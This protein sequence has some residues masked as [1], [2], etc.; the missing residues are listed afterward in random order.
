MFLSA[1][2]KKISIFLG[3][4]TSNLNFL[5][6]LYCI[7]I[8]IC[9]LFAK[10]EAQVDVL[11]SL[12]NRT[13][14]DLKT[15]VSTTIPVQDVLLDSMENEMNKARSYFYQSKHG[16]ALEIYDN[17][18]K[19]ALKT[20]N[21]ILEA[22]CY[23]G[24]GTN[25]F[26]VNNNDSLMFKYL[27]KAKDIFEKE[28]DPYFK[29][30]IYT[31]IASAYSEFEKLEKAN[32]YYQKAIDIA[33]SE[34]YTG[35]LSNALTN[36]GTIEIFEK[37]NYTKGIDALL[38]V[39]DIINNLENDNTRDSLGKVC[40]NLSY[41]YFKVGNKEKS[42]FY[43]NKGVA[44]AKKNG[45]LYVLYDL[46]DQQSIFYFED[47]KYKEAYLHIEEALFLK[48]SLNTIKDYE[49]AKQI[50]ADNFLKENKEQ[51]LLVE[52]EKEFQDTTLKRT[53][54]YNIL[55]AFFTLGLL[56][57]IYFIFKKNKQL[58]LAKEKAENLSKVKSDFYSEISH[59]LRTPL[60]AVIELSRLL[61]SENVNSEHK[62]Y[63][64]SLN[65]SGN[66]LL[67]L[68]NNVLEIN[69]V[70]HGD[71]KI[72]T[73]EFKLKSLINNITE[74]LEYALRDS[75]NKIHLSYDEN[76][77]ILL[78]GDSLKLSQIF[79]N[80]ISNAIKFTKKGNIYITTKLI[81]DL[82]DEVQVFFEVRDDGLGISKEKQIM[83]FEEF[84]QEHT[85]NK[86]SYKGTGLGLSIV[87]R[88]LTAMGSEINIDSEINQGAAFNFEI[89]LTKS[90]TVSSKEK[91][92]EAL[93]KSLADKK[94]LIVDDNKVNQLVTKKILDQ[95]NI[96]AKTVNS[97]QKAI[98]II[99]DE[100]FDCILM[101]LH[102]PDLDGYETTSLIRKFNKD[103]AIV[104]L[105]AAST[106]EVES[107]IN[108]FDM[109]GYILKP[110][111]TSDFL[112]T[113]YKVTLKA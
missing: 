47:E 60:Y 103:I 90:D 65:F 73:L 85:K 97:G 44:F 66:H 9:S 37:E 81:E 94:I 76:I 111:M 52:K 72:Q 34:N 15:S 107:K 5:K 16:K 31:I 68:I 67:S 21:K 78:E 49:K 59:E 79:I 54:F 41:A 84:Y 50:E 53:K 6:Y 32:E 86:N 33:K 7:I 61:L 55:F 45:Y 46:Y 42:L 29:S 101:D 87:K 2:I 80:L 88:M 93:L 70:E 18:L 25:Y 10:M 38:E 48:D 1:N 17:V 109:N 20:K 69:K 83:I 39:I 105:T 108:N 62:E 96:E 77:P 28:N 14:K 36:I 104:A 56:L 3:F 27:F 91:G 106:D 99:Q 113:I 8:L 57:S 112:E 82:G 89:I 13:N 4:K 71:M 51:L 22:K 110:F 58:S 63:L 35:V 40:Y 75:H 12:K 95:L 23:T 11:D 64:E 98:D 102:M 43:F 100:D 24:L 92:N 30:T 26:K 19:Y 74:S